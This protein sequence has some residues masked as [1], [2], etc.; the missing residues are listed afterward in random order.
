M[1]INSL[2]VIFESSLS[3]LGLVDFKEIKCVLQFLDNFCN[4]SISEVNFKII[5]NFLVNLLGQEY[6]K[7]FRLPGLCL[8]VFKIKAK[9]FWN[10]FTKM[11]VGKQNS[12]YSSMILDIKFGLKSILSIRSV[13]VFF[14]RTQI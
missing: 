1:K 7:V 9:F 12:F 8:E 2:D 5:M 13:L 6:N 3:V 10:W 11:W 14:V 4:D